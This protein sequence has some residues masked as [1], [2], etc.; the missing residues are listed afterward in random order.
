MICKNVLLK[1]KVFSIVGSSQD[2]LA[3][4]CMI[5]HEQGKQLWSVLLG[6]E[7]TSL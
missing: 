7:S 5:L 4:D 3:G 2:C 1:E 6:L